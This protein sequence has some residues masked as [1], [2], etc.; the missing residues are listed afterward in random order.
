M[1]VEQAL[2]LLD[3]GV[4]DH[5]FGGRQRRV[6]DDGLAPDELL[7]DLDEARQRDRL[8]APQIEDLVIEARVDGRDH[9]VDVVVDERPVALRAAFVENAQRLARQRFCA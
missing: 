7:D 6:L 8:A 3:V 1:I 4:R 2:G 5:R 9:A